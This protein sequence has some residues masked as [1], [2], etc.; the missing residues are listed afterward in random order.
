MSVAAAPA[1]LPSRGGARPV[2]A[3][4]RFR[5]LSWPRHACGSSHR[6]TDIMPGWLR[7][8][9]QPR[10]KIWTRSTAIRGFSLAKSN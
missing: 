5:W 2:A 3:V 9:P 10:H 6:G 8:P 4:L 7:F 1:R